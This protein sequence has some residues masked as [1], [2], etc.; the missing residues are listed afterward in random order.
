MTEQIFKWQ[1][2]E[3][4]DASIIQPKKNK[5]IASASEINGRTWMGLFGV[6]FS[7]NGE[8]RGRKRQ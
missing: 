3:M 1:E 2:F 8:W 4:V 6:F 7:S 5:W